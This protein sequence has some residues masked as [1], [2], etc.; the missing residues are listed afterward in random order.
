[1]KIISLWEPWAT[2][3]VRGYKKWETRGW[4]TSYRGPLAI[5]A[6]KTRQAIDDAGLLLTGA[7]IKKSI[8][9]PDPFPMED[10][11]WPFGCIVAVCFLADCKRTEAVN[12]TTQ[13]QAL[14]DYS[15]GR[16]AWILDAVRV[17][18]PLPH[19]GMQGLKDLP[20]EVEAKLEFVEA[21]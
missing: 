12:P 1:M 21:T 16:F 17:V 15:P 13:E 14:G 18:K 9:D 19:R 10:G 8:F 7:G 5:H 3:I 11:D 2:F 20:P 4:P 6:A